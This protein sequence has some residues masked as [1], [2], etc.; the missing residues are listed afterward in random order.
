[1]NPI[2]INIIL[3]GIG[4]LGS[5]IINQIIEKQQALLDEKNIE[6][7]FPVITNST[8]AFFESED[9][10]NRWNADFTKSSAPFAIQNIIDYTLEEELENLIAIDATNSFEIL[11]SY[12]T[13]IESGFNIL[14]FNTNASTQ[15]SAFYKEINNE[16][17]KTDKKFLYQKRTNKITPSNLLNHIFKAISFTASQQR[18]AS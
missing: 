9:K 2:K 17:K 7:R 16:L 8:L 11:N 18:Q 4:N 6:I 15:Q 14:A 5:N 13:L 3:F 1:M 10:K 12:T